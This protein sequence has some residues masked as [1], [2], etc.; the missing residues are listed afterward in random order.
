[1]IKMV[2]ILI[3]GKHAQQ[4]LDGFKGLTPEQI[5][6]DIS[7]SLDYAVKNGSFSVESLVERLA[8]HK[9]TGKENPKK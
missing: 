8:E 2:Q 7:K 4:I 5:V 9:P 3:R 6:Q 1:M